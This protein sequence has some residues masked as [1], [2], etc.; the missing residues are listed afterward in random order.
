MLKMSKAKEY[1]IMI[2]GDREVGKTSI[3]KWFCKFNKQEYKPEYKDGF[4]INLLRGM[5]GMDP[6][7]FAFSMD[8]FPFKAGKFFNPFF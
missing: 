4:N 1:R 6:I 5:V 3:I 7:I 2:L 8:G